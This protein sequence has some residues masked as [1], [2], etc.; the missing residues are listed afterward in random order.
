MIHKLFTEV[1]CDY[2]ITCNQTHE[3]LEI[4]SNK[5]LNNESLEIRSAVIINNND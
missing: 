4:Y 3:F 5:S 1:V 2:T